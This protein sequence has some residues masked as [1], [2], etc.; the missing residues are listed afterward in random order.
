MRAKIRYRAIILLPLVPG[1]P[2]PLDHQDAGP[3]RLIMECQNR[4]IARGQHS[5]FA[6]LRREG[7]DPD[8]YISFFALRGWGKLKDGSLTTEAVYIHAKCMIV[9]DRIAI[10]GSANVCSVLSSA[11]SRPNLE[12]LPPDQR[13]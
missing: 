4:T 6:K 8:D 7:I 5:I 9:D 10:I 1:Y 12:S 3:V 13:T 2:L 11:S